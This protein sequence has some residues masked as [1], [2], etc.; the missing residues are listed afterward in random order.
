[1][2]M[3]HNKFKS[4]L[5]AS[6]V[7]LVPG[8]AFAQDTAAQDRNDVEEIT[9]QG[10][11][12]PDEK[13]ATSEIANILDSESFSQAGD[14]DVAV[15]LQRVPGLSVVGGK[16]VFVRGLGDRYSS[17]L[18]NGS[19]IP[20]PEPLRR[21][22]PLDIFPTAMIENVLVQKTYSPE[23]P[24]SFGGGVI[25]LRTKTIPDEFVLEL[26]V[27][28][29]VNTASTFKKGLSYDGSG[30]EI[31]GFGGSMRNIPKEILADVTL[32]SLTPAELEAAGEAL[33]NIWSIDEEKNLPGGSFNFL[34]GNRYDVGSESAWGFFAAVTYDV[35]QT[36]QFGFQ[37]GFNTSNAGLVERYSFSPEVCDSYDGAG[38]DCGTRQTEME[39]NLNGIL[40]L[41]YEI[42]ANNSL[43]LTSMVLR[44]SKKTSLIQKGFTASEKDELRT[45]SYIDWTESQVL[46]NQ[47][48]GEHTFAL[49]GDNGMFQDM[50]F[51]WRVNYSRADR[52]APLRREITYVFD[53][54]DDVFRT[55]ARSDA[56]TTSY[57]ALDDESYEAGFNFV[58][59]M[60]I[61]DFA[62]DIKGGFT[63]E[64]KE[65][66]YGVV[67][68]FFDFPAGANFDLRELVPEII[69]GPANIA[70]GGIELAEKFDPSDYFTASFENKQGYLGADVQVTDKLRA[71]FGMRY[72]NSTQIVSTV[73]RTTDTPVVV[74]QNAEY[75]LPSAT[76]TYEFVDNMQLR[77][78]YSQTITRPD[79][80]ELSSAPFI[81]DERRRTVR[82]NLNLQITEINNYDARFEW[83]FAAGESVTLGLFYKEFSNPIEETFTILGEGPLQGYINADSA[84]LKGVELEVHKILPL[85]DWLGWDWLG[86]REVYVRAN[87]SYIDSE[88]IIDPSSSFASTATNLVRSMQGQSD[89]LGNL[90]FG[91]ED[92][93]RG[94]S[95]ALVLNYTGKRLSGVGIN[96]VQDEYEVPPMMLNFVYRKE[97]EIGSNIV[98]LKME[99]ENILGDKAEW[100]QEGQIVEQ[101]D[102]GR[103][104][105]VG[106]TYKF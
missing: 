34:W 73:D 51:D 27:G 79:M 60:S 18:L 61:G 91:W 49:F 97:L 33:P 68:Y 23:Y 11:Y 85:Q 105:A 63:Y 22:V 31:L 2:K 70:P 38:D 99:A 103:T 54:N 77:L 7:L 86:S 8:Q 15:A 44:Q 74:T 88:T 67:R 21:V 104:F 28:T 89:W 26:G 41:G 106:V 25:D 12:I 96:G 3:N 82:G 17:T 102:L 5:L 40:S 56:N 47:L 52:D 94:E 78:A 35:E 66:S 81:N 75:W 101:Y 48:S 57:S 58:Q 43:N 95:L 32:E 55:L 29:K 83:Y 71:A 30:S 36:N 84:E 65:R 45:L 39:I 20:S 64:D 6:T 46:T 98:E 87:G 4:A 16:Y 24:A 53:D 93:E 1:M 13:R 50:D 59:P 90:Q 14:S 100:T 62:V 69:F 10:R 92:V 42:N 9:V 19:S 37:K 80:R 72:E 76:L